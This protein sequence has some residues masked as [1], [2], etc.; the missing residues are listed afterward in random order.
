MSLDSVV[1]AIVTVAL[2]AYLT[3]ALLRPEKF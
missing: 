3:Y 2:L 1:G